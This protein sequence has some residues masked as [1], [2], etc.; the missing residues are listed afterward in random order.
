MDNS[1]EP[2][3]PSELER[4]IFELAA[5]SDPSNRLNYLLTAQRTNIWL[6]HIIYETVTQV[7]RA[8]R[9]D[10]SLTFPV[11]SEHRRRVRD[12]LLGGTVDSALATEALKQCPEVT[13]LALWC[14]VTRDTLDIISHLPLRR[15]SADFYRLM[16]SINRDNTYTRLPLSSFQGLTHLEFSSYCSDWQECRELAEL[17]RLT[18]LSF[19]KGA[20]SVVLRGALA[21]CKA[22]QV[23]VWL[24]F[25][26]DNSPLFECQPKTHVAS[27]KEKR[28]VHLSQPA[29]AI[30]SNWLAET[31]GD[32]CYWDFA[33]MIISKR[34]GKNPVS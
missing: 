22:M 15:L 5:R 2:R 27:V 20:P 1:L 25:H 21:E 7:Y 9:A 29:D 31:R 24:V 3:L 26:Y 4:E 32:K 6:E 30:V 11:P 8:G 16:I 17:P 19:N 10:N 33:E 13:N 12:L 18:H 23:L 34:V 14:S 28:L